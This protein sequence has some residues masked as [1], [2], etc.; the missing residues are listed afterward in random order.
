MCGFVKGLL[1]GVIPTADLF[2]QYNA[3]FMDFYNHIKDQLSEDAAGHLQVEIDNL[4]DSIYNL[5]DSIA[6]QY[7]PSQTYDKG[8]VRMYHNKRYHSNQAIT[9]PEPWTPEHWTEENIDEALSEIKSNSAVVGSMTIF[10]GPVVPNGYL[11]CD[12]QAVSRSEYSKLFE[13]IGTT[14]GA[15]D[16]STTVN[17]PDMREVAPVGVGQSAR[18]EGEHDTYAFGEFK[19]DQ[20]QSHTH[21]IAYWATSGPYNINGT[22][23]SGL[24]SK[25]GT[26]K[27]DGRG[28]TVTR[29]KRIGVNYIIKY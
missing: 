6:P 28:G 15:G 19:D 26:G 29:G 8:W 20:L 27:N 3:I 25:R 16:G 13:V 12:G 23:G 9:E 18:T 24:S 5:S 4:S 21:S 2:S 1:Q 17:V 11:L 22:G 7:D 14:W 10:A